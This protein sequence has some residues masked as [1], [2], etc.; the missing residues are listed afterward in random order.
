MLTMYDGAGT[1]RALDTGSQSVVLLATMESR[2][3][4]GSAPKGSC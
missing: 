2:R 1:V 4:W 3:A